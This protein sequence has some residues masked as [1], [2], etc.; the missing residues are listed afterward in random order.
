M[1]PYGTGFKTCETCRASARLCGQKKRKKDKEEEDSRAAKHKQSEV[2]SLGPSSDDPALPQGNIDDEGP[3]DEGDDENDDEPTWYSDSEELF[4]ALRQ[5][6][7][8][9]T[10]VNFYRCYTTAEDP[11]VTDKQCI[12]MTAYAIWKATGYRFRVKEYKA[13]QMGV[14]ACMW[15]SQDQNRKQKSCPSEREGAKP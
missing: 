9:N 8:Q 6:F 4:A 14:L 5:S 3:E 1:I 15:Y 12:Q 2:Q 7:K 10:S 13:L 11:L